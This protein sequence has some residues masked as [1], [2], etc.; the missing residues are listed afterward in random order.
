MEILDRAELMRLEAQAGLDRA[1]TQAERNKLGQFATPAALASDIMEYA[2]NVLSKDSGIHFL[3][4]AFGTGSFYSAF[5]RIFPAQRVASATGYE[6]DPLYAEA[7]ARIWGGTSMEIKVADFTLEKP[8]AT[9]A[10]KANLLICNPPYVRHHHLDKETKARLGRTAEI[11]SGVRPSGLSGL[12]CHFLLISHAWMAQG[13]LAGWLI[14][15]EFMG[16]GYGRKIREYLLDRVTLLRIHRFDPRNAQFE[17]A[18]VSSA[19]VWLE[20]TPPTNSHAVEL[21]CGGTLLNPETSEVVPSETLRGDTK[22]TAFPR[23][24]KERTIRPSGWKLSDLFE[25]KRGLATGAN[26]FFLLTPEQAVEHRLPREFLKPILPSPRYLPTDEVES[27]EKDEPLLDRKKFLLSCDLPEEEVK[28]SYPDLWRYLRKGIESGIKERYLCRH[29]RPWYS[30]ENRPP[31]SLLCTYMNRRGSEDGRLFRFILN[32]SQATAPNVYLML[33][34]KPI[35][36]GVLG[37]RPESIRK[38]W[39]ALN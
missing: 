29:R 18:L 23:A 25:I 11:A 30:Q 26:E 37:D 20:N 13:G 36:R 15:S 10:E 31:V 12:Y 5:S 22:W 39:L 24:S 7:A 32:H 27:D 17:D 38:A 2:K 34:P 6:V 14:P 33:Y 35:L 4:P 21:T 19:V 28:H 8:P 3:D 9:A 16:V 1:K